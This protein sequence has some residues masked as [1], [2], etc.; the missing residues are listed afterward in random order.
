M[1]VLVTSISRK[2]PLLQAL[3]TALGRNI[4]EGRLHGADADP[5]CIGR[6]FVDR[7]W[8]MPPLTSLTLEELLVYC[9]THAIGAIVPTRDGELPFLAAARESLAADGVSVMVSAPEAIAWCGDKLVFAERLIGRGFPAIPTSTEPPATA[10]V[11][12][13]ERFGAGAAGAAGPLTPS[14]A[15][16]QGRRLG[17]AVYQPYIAG[18]EFSIDLYRD[19]H[20]RLHGTLARRRLLVV[21]GESQVTRSEKMPQL[22]TLCADAAAHLGLYG[23]AVFQVIV[24]REGKPW[25]VEC[26]PRL[27]GASTLAF[28]MGLDSL[29]WFLRESAG[30]D[31]AGVPFVRAEVEQTLVRHAQDRIL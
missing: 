30:E 6:H 28:A 19:R 26:N 27:G 18:T 21:G 13:K 12:V 31:L 11:M 16:E 8:A 4:P 20:G 29:G 22:E 3:R 9:R 5:D 14:A 25:L 10:P 2:V 7:F 17:A 23:H 24:D 1:N 15:R